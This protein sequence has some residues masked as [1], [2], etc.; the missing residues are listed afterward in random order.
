MDILKF[1]LLSLL[2]ITFLISTSFAQDTCTYTTYKWNV[3][4]KKAVEFEKV[5]HSYSALER[6]EIDLKT[7]CTVCEEDQEWID[8]G[9]IPRFRICKVLAPNIRKVLSNAYD[10][11]FTFNK[12]IGYRVGMTRGEIDE[13]GNR[14]QFSN[15]SFGIAIDINEDQNGLYDQCI[16]FSDNC[17]LRKG[18]HW[19]PG[20]KG[21]LIKQEQIKKILCTFLQPVTDMLIGLRSKSKMSIKLR[22]V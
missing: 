16:E 14:T 17:R 18:G 7:Q 13:N 5:S 22:T 8:V 6:H 11:G 10:S 15:H 4:L 20:V 3:D 9:D 2:L 1:T 19:R 21:T 12:V